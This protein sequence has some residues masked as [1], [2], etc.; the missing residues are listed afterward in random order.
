MSLIEQC[1]KKALALPKE[2][3]QEFLDLMWAGKTIGQ[4]QN[5]CN[6]GFDEA[7]GIMNLNIENEPTLR[8]DT[9]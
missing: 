7:I 2:K 8:R 6:I 5:I 4:S 1:M 3:R 9:V